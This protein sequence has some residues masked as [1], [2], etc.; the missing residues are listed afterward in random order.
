MDFTPKMDKLYFMENPMNKWDDLG[1]KK[2]QQPFWNPQSLKVWL[3][4]EFPFLTGDFQ[5]PA[6]NFPGCISMRN[7]SPL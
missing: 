6:M 4:D 1:G 3:E 7:V 2:V 5:V